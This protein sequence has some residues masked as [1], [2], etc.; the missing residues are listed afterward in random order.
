MW[1]RSILCEISSRDEK[2]RWGSWWWCLLPVWQFH[3]PK[4]TLY[5]H[6]VYSALSFYSDHLTRRHGGDADTLCECG[7]SVTRCRVL[8]A[9]RVSCV[10]WRCRAIP[11]TSSP[12]N[13]KQQQ[14]QLLYQYPSYT[15][16]G[17]R[18]LAGYCGK[19]RVA[20]IRDL[21]AIIWFTSFLLLLV[22]SK[23]IVCLSCCQPIR[24]NRTHPSAHNSAEVYSVFHHIVAEPR[25]NQ[26]RHWTQSNR[27]KREL[28]PLMQ[29]T[30]HLRSHIIEF[31]R[32]GHRTR[33]RFLDGLEILSRPA[34]CCSSQC[35]C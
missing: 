10:R 9:P 34:C 25:F 6:D 3:K 29:N 14:L 24:I 27:D 19:K 21:C 7:S 31:H 17:Y 5:I 20:L 13:A 32:S 22:T 33:C 8:C 2:G 12:Q 28:F 18:W 16:F 11:S 4:P 1:R 23:L 15:A 26:M 35:G 30:S